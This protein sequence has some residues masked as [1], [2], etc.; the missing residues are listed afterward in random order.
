MPFI[1]DS[2]FNYSWWSDVTEAS[3]VFCSFSTDRRTEVARARLR[4]RSTVG[5]AYGVNARSHAVATEIERLEVRVDHRN[6]GV[7]HE[8]V[9]LLLAKFQGPW[10]AISLDETSHLFWRS[11]RWNKHDH[12]HERGFPLFAY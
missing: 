6:R 2:G 10:V 7:G 11:L 3:L 1:A 4:R 8:V 5:S 9:A 12:P